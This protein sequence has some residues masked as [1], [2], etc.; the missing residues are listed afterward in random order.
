LEKIWKNPLPF[1]ACALAMI[2][3]TTSL[4]YVLFNGSVWG[5]IIIVVWGAL[6]LTFACYFANKVKKAATKQ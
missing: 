4:V 5:R 2:I 3:M 6:V 1:V